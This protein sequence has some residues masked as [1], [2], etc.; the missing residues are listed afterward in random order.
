MPGWFL[1]FVRS[2]LFEPHRSLTFL[3]REAIGWEQNLTSP[4]GNALRIHTVGIVGAG[5]MGRGLAQNVSE[6]G[7]EAVLVD[8]TDELALEARRGLE[9]SLNRRLEKWAITVAE[10][11]AILGRIK[12]SSHMEEI[13]ISDLVI[14]SVTENMDVKKQVFA[15]LDRFA[16]PEVVLASNSSTLSI[17]EMAQATS[18]P[19]RVIGLHFL[20]PVTETAVVEIVRGLKTADD[21]FEVARGFVKALGKTGVQVYESPGFV[22]TRLFIPLVNEAMY[23]LMEGVASA[24]DIDTAMRLGYEWERGPLEMADRIGLD[25]LLAIME[26]LFREYG[27]LKFRAC[28]LLKKYVRAG[29]LGVKN[30]HGFFVYDSEGNRLAEAGAGS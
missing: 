1:A 29:H 8:R 28:P 18:R 12:F 27:E 22:T 6:K 4:G 5:T 15:Q 14:E 21:T 3:R 2:G 26:T 16:R 17:T 11:R 24:E 9:I 25:T 13:S 23:A 10:K 19:G 30:G 20:N 7:F